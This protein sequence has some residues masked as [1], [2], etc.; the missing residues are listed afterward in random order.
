MKYW[1]R[2]ISLTILMCM[3]IMT[4]VAQDDGAVY[5]FES[6]IEFTVP[7]GLSIDTSGQFPVVLINDQTVMDVIDPDTISE[8]PDA[9]LNA[10]LDEVLDFLLGAVGYGDLRTEEE[11]SRFNLADGREIAAFDFENDNGAV[12][13]IFTIRL[14]DGRVGALNFRSLEGITQQTLNIILEVAVSLDVPALS[15]E[16]LVEGLPE[17]VVYESGVR[18]RYPQGLDIVNL[19]DPPATIGIDGEILITMVDPNLINMPAGEAMEDIVAFAIESTPLT[20]SDFTVFDIG[21][22]EAVIGTAQDAEF[23]STLVLVRFSDTTVGIMDI[24]TLVD[25]T[26]AHIDVVRRIAASF[27]TELSEDEMATANLNQANLLF[28]RAINLRD[29]GDNEGAIELFNQ[30]IELNPNLGLAYYWRGATYQRLANLEN[31]VADFRQAIALTPEQTQILVDIAD[32]YAL[33]GDAES[34]VTELEAFI[35]QV[36]V[37]RVEQGQ[38]DA[39]AIYREIAAGGYI[40]DYYFARATRLRQYG[41]Y[42]L[43]LAS[44]QILL[45]NA[46]DNPDFHSQQGVIYLESGDIDASIIAFTTAIEFNP[47]PLYFFNRGYA[48]S[49][50]ANAP[51]QLIESV[52]DYQCVILLADDTISDEQRNFAQQGI[53]SAIIESDDYEPITDPANCGA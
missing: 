50:T 25:P 45:D 10:P 40:S 9:T 3:L 39:L 43:A 32:V 7:D 5:T 11:T 42:E 53:D 35:A 15:E 20:L 47:A 21:G 48:Y 18:F 37:E 31:A 22:R 16:E 36:G 49:L 24:R 51:L 27:N 1:V 44:N 29:A 4:A 8:T 28:E 33:Y 6:G 52:H 19:D 2:Y 41:Q 23:V 46:P 34:A 30:A 14:S 17:S 13:T 26:P 12:Q 38:L